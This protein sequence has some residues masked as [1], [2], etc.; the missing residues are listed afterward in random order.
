[1]MHVGLDS[2]NEFFAVHAFLSFRPSTIAVQAFRP[3]YHFAWN[4]CTRIVFFPEFSFDT[5]DKL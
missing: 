1:M 3:P 4:S 2:S 5:T